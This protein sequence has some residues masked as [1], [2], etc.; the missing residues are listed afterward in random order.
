MSI[1]HLPRRAALRCLGSC[2]AA[3]PLSFPLASLPAGLF[4]R[5]LSP[6]RA[7]GLQAAEGTPG[8]PSRGASDRGHTAE[9]EAGECGRSGEGA[10]A[11]GQFP[12]RAARERGMCSRC[13]GS[14]VDTVTPLLWARRGSVLWRR[15][16]GCVQG[17]GSPGREDLQPS[18]DKG[19]LLSPGASRVLFWPSR[20][21]QNHL[22]DFHVLLPCLCRLSHPTL[23]RPS[24]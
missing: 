14:A 6:R 17:C 3:P 8:P 22:P 11:G 19:S 5:R 18:L 13:W 2:T 12:R 4:L 23:H 15:A 21:L 10:G 16:Q 9:G 7:A 24:Q 1:I 20:P